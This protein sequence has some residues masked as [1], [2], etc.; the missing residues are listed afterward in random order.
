VLTTKNRLL[1]P[2]FLKSVQ[3]HIS[4]KYYGEQPKGT[5]FIL[6][7]TEK[8]KALLAKFVCWV[9]LGRISQDLSIDTAYSSL[10]ASLLAIRQ[11]NTTIAD[12]K[13]KISSVACPIIPIATRVSEPT[14]ESARQMALACKMFFDV[15]RNGE[16]ITIS[17]GKARHTEIVTSF[18]KTPEERER[19]LEGLLWS[20]DLLSRGLCR[21]VLPLPTK[22]KKIL[23]A[24]PL[25][26]ASLF[27]FL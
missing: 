13:H 21:C 20:R 25:F 7:V 15:S 14:K 24:A 3:H 27:L 18:P 4:D 16:P 1:G 9:C 6:P 23:A 22:K 5:A 10:W 26:L 12:K 11:Q 19:E 17:M 8:K 2:K